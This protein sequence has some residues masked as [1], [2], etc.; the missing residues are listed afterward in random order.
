MLSV[1][2]CISGSKEN[3][4]TRANRT[5]SSTV[6]PAKSAFARGRKECFRQKYPSPL[7]GPP[8][9]PLQAPFAAPPVQL[10]FRGRG[11]PWIGRGVAKNGV[12]IQPPVPVASEVF[13]NDVNTV[14]YPPITLYEQNEFNSHV[15]ED[16]G[17][18]YGQDDTWG[19]VSIPEPRGRGRGH[20][21]ARPGINNDHN[22]FG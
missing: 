12:A 11:K 13:A 20:P 9:P 16:F 6:G 5:H 18:N 15:F 22:N 17:T 21:Y 19:K 3:H 7:R 4:A 1:S 8:P 14:A 10:P 2:P